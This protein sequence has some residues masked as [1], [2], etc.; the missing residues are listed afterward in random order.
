MQLLDEIGFA[1]RHAAAGDDD[2]GA[3]GRFANARSSSAGSSRTTPMSITS[4]PSRVS[5]P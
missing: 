1:D 3:A 4:Q 5:M 2:V